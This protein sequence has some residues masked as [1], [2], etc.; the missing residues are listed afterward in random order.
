[1]HWSRECIFCPV[2]RRASLGHRAL[3][4]NLSDIAAMGASPSWALLSLNL[5]LADERWLRRIRGRF[6]R[7]GARS[8]GGTGGRQPEPRCAVDYRAAGGPGAGGRGTAA[9]RCASRRRAVPERQRRRC[10][11]RVENFARRRGRDA[12][13]RRLAAAAFRVSRPR[14]WPWGRRCA[15]SPAPAS[16]SP[17]ACTS[18]P[19]ACWRPVGCGATLEIE[20]LPLSPALRRTLGDQ[21]WRS[22]AVGRRGLR[23]VLYRRTGAERARWRRWQ[24]RTGQAVTRIGALHAGTGLTLQAAGAVMQFS[25]SGFDHFGN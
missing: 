24:Q 7:A 11:L 15:A 1:M 6:R 25:P 21:A 20:R 23:A 2:R 4:V 3:A 5:P 16:M 19:R 22:G 12:G 10:R 14:A 17:T 9:R 8:C 13:R 18:M